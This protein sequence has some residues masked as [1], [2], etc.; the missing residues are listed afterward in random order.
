[1]SGVPTPRVE[2]PLGVWPVVGVRRFGAAAVVERN[3]WVYRRT[4]MILL[5]GAAEPL[6]YLGAVGLGIGRL[7]GDVP[8]PGGVLVPYSV[9]VA[10]ALLAASAM[11]GA[12]YE[13]T[14]NIFFKLRYGRIYEAMLA[15][16][17]RPLDIAVGE[18]AWS[19]ARG[20]LYAIG[21]LIVMASLGLTRSPLVLLALPGAV[22]IGTAFGAVG[23]ALSSWMRSWQDFDLIQLFLLPLFLFSATFFPLDVYPPALRP[24]VQLSPLYHGTAL[25][26]SLSLGV[27]S[28]VLLAHVA[29]LLAMAAA[30]AAVAGRRFAAVL[31]R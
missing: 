13:S 19:Q 8:G 1:M 21:F 6:L 26:R 18:I 4:W 24:L 3:L 22:L 17:I 20:L 27:L 10:P 31:T 28:P 23:M 30:G 7:V 25:L 11:N 14:M 16:P 2:P 15:T 29:F 12:V 5:S 9:Y